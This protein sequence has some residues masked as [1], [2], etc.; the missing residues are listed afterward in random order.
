M[1]KN[2]SDF[3][4][5]CQILKVRTVGAIEKEKN[6]HGENVVASADILLEDASSSACGYPNVSC[7]K[8][9]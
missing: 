9:K 2:T 4:I 1:S 6:T 8:V 5:T 3:Q 7:N